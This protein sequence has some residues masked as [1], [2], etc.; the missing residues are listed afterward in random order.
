M[1]YTLRTEI[2]QKYY[3]LFLNLKKT[4][5][6]FLWPKLNVEGNFSR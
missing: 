3:A 4:R 2:T 5:P 6:Q 1:K